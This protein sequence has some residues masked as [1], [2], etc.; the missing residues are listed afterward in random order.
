[1]IFNARIS[2]NSIRALRHDLLRTTVTSLRACLRLVTDR[3]PRR[4][5]WEV[6]VM[7]FGPYA[8]RPHTVTYRMLL[9]FVIY[10][11]VAVTA[12]IK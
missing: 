7:E 2:T 10:L 4:S 1:M 11:Q 3:S 9:V 8:A 12:R 5:Y 6:A